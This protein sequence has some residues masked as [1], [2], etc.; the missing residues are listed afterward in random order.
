VAASLAALLPVA[1]EIS[2]HMPEV[3]QGVQALID[4]EYY[5]PALSAVSSVR[6]TVGHKKLTAEAD[7]TVAAVA[8]TYDYLNAVLKHHPPPIVN[9]TAYR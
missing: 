6:S 8:G 4:F 9:P 5:V 2:S 3:I 7:M 1:G